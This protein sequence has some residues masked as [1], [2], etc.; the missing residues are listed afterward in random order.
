V[1]ERFIS[2]RDERTMA[3]GKQGYFKTQR[4]HKTF[5]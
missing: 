2:L 5:V 4:T 1:S 3:E